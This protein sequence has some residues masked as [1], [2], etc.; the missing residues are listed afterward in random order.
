MSTLPTTC[1]V[2]AGPAGLAAARAFLAAGLPVEVF[3]RHSA[4]GGLWD[5]DN[6]GSPIYESAH[7]ISSKT[8]SGYPG[9]DMPAHFPDYPSHRQILSYLHDFADRYE[10]GRVINFDCGVRHAEWVDGAW[11]VGLESG[12]RRRFDHLICANGTQ[13]DPV[14]PDIPGEFTGRLIH[15]SQHWSAEEFRNQRVLVIGAGNSGVDI[16]CDAAQ[17]GRA[18]VLSMRRGYHVVPKHIFGQPA[19]VFADAGPELPVRLSQTVFAAVLRILHGKPERLGL[20]RPDHKLFETHP[21]LNTEIFHYLSHGDLRIAVDVDR[22]DGDTVHFVDGS[23]SEFDTVVCA[24]GYRCSVRY[25]DRSNFEWKHERP[26]L[27]LHA[28]SPTNPHLHAIGFTE[29]DGGA[30]TLFDNTAVAIAG[31]VRMLHERPE[32][33]DEWLRHARSDRPDL[34]GGVKH[35]D[36]A[37]HVNY[38]HV[39]DYLKHLKSLSSRFGWTAPDPGRYRSLE[40]ASVNP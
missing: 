15:S 35:I 7:F 5:P 14:L 3:E 36:S 32:R 9:F 23:S 38:L 22:F 26:Q 1:V 16:A 30:Y 28:F 2:G 31:L 33:R 25:L 21:I 34:R 11:D 18:A 19:D 12:A 40:S 4:V 37:R 20:P 29:G 8:M 17:A 10:L 13:W 6:E 39:K 27:Y 24:T